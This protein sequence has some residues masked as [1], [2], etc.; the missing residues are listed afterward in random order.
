MRFV[1]RVG[2]H[3]KNSRQKQLNKLD[4]KFTTEKG[5]PGEEKEPF[6]WFDIDEDRPS[7]PMVKKLIAQWGVSDFL[8]TEYSESEIA[9]ATWLE[10]LSDWHHGYPQPDELDD[11]YLEATYDLSDA[12]ERCG[13]G[14]VQK[15][16]FQMKGEPR[17]GKRSILQMNWVF[18]EHFVTPEVWKSVFRAHGIGCRPVTNTKGAELKTVVQLIVDEEV[19]IEA[20]GLPGAVCP[21]C[22]RMKYLPVSRG[23]LPPLKS[24]PSFAMV[25]TKECFG[26]GGQAFKAVL[27]SKALRETFA[28]QNVRGASF[29]PIASKAPVP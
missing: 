8:R 17:W 26:D 24:E 13:T 16:P 14:R 6:I 22:G 12:C 10:L 2:F 3:A 20:E 23:P 28:S 25:K 5:L 4:V 9:T 15:A 1:H 21:N 18:D 29:A 19:G 7:W 11:G 27:V